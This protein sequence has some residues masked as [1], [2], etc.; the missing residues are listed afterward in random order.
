MGDESTTVDVLSLEDFQTT[1]TARLAE[2]NA[3]LTTVNTTLQGAPPRLGGFQDAVDTAGRYSELH[4]EHS[5]GVQRLIDAITAAQSAT[6]TIINS[7]NTTEAR[8][9]ANVSEIANTLSPL[10]EV[11]NGGQANA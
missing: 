1:L 11:L 10:G 6:T 9:A 8:N 2:A 3:L 7:Y 4:G 5:S